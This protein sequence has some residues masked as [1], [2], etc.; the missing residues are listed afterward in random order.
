MM[1]DEKKMLSIKV[2]QDYI[3]SFNYAFPLCILLADDMYEE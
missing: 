3:T 2:Q 1:L